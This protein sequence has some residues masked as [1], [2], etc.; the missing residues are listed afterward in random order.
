MQDAVSLITMRRLGWV[1]ALI[2]AVFVAMRIPHTLAIFILAA[3]IAFGVAPVTY[4]LETRMPRGV[5]IAV[6]YSVLLL[7]IVVV[8]ILVVPAAIAQAQSFLEVMPLQ[9]DNLQTAFDGGTKHFQ[10]RF[11]RSFGLG[12]QN[13]RDLLNLRIQAGASLAFASLGTV[14]LNL[15]TSIFVFISALVLSAFFVSRSEGIAAGFRKLFP[16]N[17]RHLA[18]E[19]EH[20]IARVF[21]GFVAGQVTLC[22]L[23]GTL[24]CGALMIMN[25]PF[26]ILVGVV[27]AVGYAVPF[28]GMVVVQLIAALLAAPLGLSRVI[29]ITVIIFIV[30]RVVDNLVTPKV[31]AEKVG[32]SPI[33][34]MF[35]VF[36]GG[37][38]FGISGLV[39]G[40]P[41]AAMVKTAWTV[42]Q[43]ARADEKN[44]VNALES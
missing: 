31:M 3:M 40:I 29:W 6:V 23:T 4:R 39:L 8:S 38:L 17:R 20:E 43:H 42:Y 9:L 5:A 14:L 28:F 35:A 26:A 41:A 24:V 25:V 7:T 19:F 27:A 18:N 11:G 33:A 32:V 37:E 30:A 34:V 22:A 10:G 44:S 12:L 36:A 13:M 15:F 21:G 1:A 2:V 16:P